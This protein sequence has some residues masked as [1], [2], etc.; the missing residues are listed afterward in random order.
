MG[1]QLR[2]DTDGRYRLPAAPRAYT[3]TASAPG[4][5]SASQSITVTAGV[6][7]TVNLGLGP[8]RIY[9]PLGLKRFDVGQPITP[10]ATATL[11]PTATMTRTP[12]PTN[13][14]SPTPAMSSPTPTATAT[15]SQTHITVDGQSND[16]AG[17][18]VLLDDP[19]GDVEA[20]FLD[21]TTGRAFVNQHTLYLLVETV[22]PR[23]PFVQ[24][25][26]LVEAGAR[27]LLISWKPGQA[28]GF[29]GDV[30]GDY[31]PVGSVVRSSFAFSPTLEARIDRRDQGL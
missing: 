12:T 2:A 26:V 13:T 31:Q 5:A 24:F 20:G 17:R 16:W 18:P 25:D 21:L 10:I 8:L 19:A 15:A 14:Q 4:Y 30:T 7:V 22:D 29:I 9:L 23:A 28:A 1:T 27:H 3:V 11:T 6:T